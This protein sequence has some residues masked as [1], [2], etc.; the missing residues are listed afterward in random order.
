M[1]MMKWTR[2]LMAPGCA[3]LVWFMVCPFL[4]WS[5]DASDIAVRGLR[6]H[7]PRVVVQPQ[8]EDITVYA[9]TKYGVA[10]RR[11]NRSNDWGPWQSFGYP[12]DIV[13]PPDKD[14]LGPEIPLSTGYYGY[15]T[16]QFGVFAFPHKANR[17]DVATV[18]ANAIQ[19]VPASYNW[20]S[21]RI[22][23]SLI[24]H[25]FAKTEFRAETMIGKRNSYGFTVYGRTDD[26]K[27][28]QSNKV[29]PLL[30]YSASYTGT[31]PSLNL[32]TVFR[33]H[34]RPN[35]TGTDASVVLGPNSVVGVPLQS[36]SG[37]THPHFVFVKAV[38][39]SLDYLTYLRRE[40]NGT[41]V[42]QE[43]LGEPPRTD[44]K[45]VDGPV[46][47]ILNT[48]DGFKIHVFVV[49]YDREEKRYQ[50]FGRTW[51]LVEGTVGSWSGWT[52]H[53][54]PLDHQ[55]GSVAMLRGD[56]KF[57]LTT[58]AV[59]KEN[60]I[61]R[62]NLFGYTDAE[63][64]DHPERL[65]EYTWDGKKW[66]WMGVHSPPQKN[67]GMRTSSM[68]V[69]DKPDYKRFSVLCRASDGNIY[70]HYLVFKNRRWAST[71]YWTDLSQ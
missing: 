64:S 37:K 31:L 8:R 4:A 47:L 38:T 69:L 55:R 36:S 62:I 16:V 27:K 21:E 9:F 20:H 49:A 33:N 2:L 50:L 35:F 1:K 46:A 7:L 57:R 58:Y 23:S 70:E 25:P 32:T 61:P 30:E 48:K 24:T 11:F 39:G 63:G 6:K 29:I 26:S 68:T 17:L 5:L 65:I 18:Y 10:Q 67:L 34:G 51:S 41:A 12:S 42:W 13:A 40:E 66:R 53:G 28:P 59:W 3:A 22:P 45:M 56:T 15:G 71:W 44:H 43:D 19:S 14:Q 60:S 54:W 52:R